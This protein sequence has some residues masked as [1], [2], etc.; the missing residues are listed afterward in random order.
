M[1]T[2][3]K[4]KGGNGGAAVS[5]QLQRTS[6]APPKLEK[7]K[8]KN[9][10]F[11]SRVSS[12]GRGQR[13]GQPGR[14]G[15]PQAPQNP[16]LS[17]PHQQRGGPPFP[18]VMPPFPY[19]PQMGG[20]GGGGPGG[21]ASSQLVFYPTGAY[22]PGQGRG[23][24]RGA[25]SAAFV[26]PHHGFVPQPYGYPS[27]QQPYA[28]P[29]M[30]N[31]YQP[32]SGAMGGSTGGVPRRQ[33]QARK[34]GQLTRDPAKQHGPSRPPRANTVPSARP[35]KALQ[36]TDPKT[37]KVITF[38]PKNK[39]SGE[40]K[41]LGVGGGSVVLDQ[42]AH[43]RVTAHASVAPAAH[44]NYNPYAPLPYQQ[45]F[46]GM[47]AQFFGG[48][49]MQ[50][51]QHMKHPHR[52][53]QPSRIQQP[54]SAIL[55]HDLKQSAK[56]KRP[57]SSQPQ[58]PQ[59]QPQ[60]Q[61]QPQPQQ[62]QRKEKRK[63]KQKQ[64][65]KQQKHQ[66]EEGQE[67]EE[68]QQPR[69]S[70]RHSQQ[71]QQHRHQRQ[72]QVQ[73]VAPHHA[74]GNDA[75]HGD[76]SSGCAAGKTARHH[77]I[78]QRTTSEPTSQPSYAAM[79][80]RH[81]VGAVD[82]ENR[83]GDIPGD[84]T[85]DNSADSSGGGPSGAHLAHAP[86]P[87]SEATDS[88]LRRAEQ[89]R[90][91]EASLA[92]NL[93]EINKRRE[94]AKR[95]SNARKMAR[96]RLE[97]L[98]RDVS[99]EEKAKIKLSKDDAAT[100]PTLGAET[101]NGD[102]TNH[103]G[104]GEPIGKNASISHANEPAAIP[105]YHIG[106]RAGR[107]Q[108]YTIAELRSVK[109]YFPYGSLES[110]THLATLGVPM[111]YEIVPSTQHSRHGANRGLANFN[112]PP[113]SSAPKSK[114]GLR[115]PNVKGSAVVGQGG[116]ARNARLG[117]R[118]ADPR[119]SVAGGKS[120]F[121]SGPFG[122]ARMGMG[123]SAFQQQQ[124]PQQQPRG[125][126]VSGG[127]MGM[128]SARG[129]A[130]NG[131]G[132]DDS[133]DWR[134]GPRRQVVAGN[135]DPFCMNPVTLHKAEKAWKPSED[136]TKSS[137]IDVWK[138][139]IGAILNKLSRENFNKLAD[140]M[141]NMPMES[142]EM[143]KE[144][145]NIIFDKALAESFYSDMYADLCREL[146]MHSATWNFTQVKSI[147]DPDTGAPKYFWAARVNPTEM[148][149]I[150]P[151]ATADEAR[152]K[153]KKETSFKRILL[154]KCQE[155]FE[156]EDLYN[157]AEEAYVALLRSAEY[158]SLD[159]DEKVRRKLQY[160]A[161]RKE[162]K[163]RMLGNVQ[164]IGE[165]FK[166]GML[167]ERIM[168]ECV[169]KMLGGRDG[170]GAAMR[171]PDGEEVEALCK[172]VTTIGLKLDHERAKNYMDTYFCRLRLLSRHPRL[173]PRTK[174]M[175]ADLIELR[176]S[177]WIPRRK[178]TIKARTKA[179]VRAEAEDEERRKEHDARHGGRYGGGGNFDRRRGRGD[180]AGGRDRRSGRAMPSAQSRREQ[181][182]R[183]VSQDIRKVTGGPGK[184]RIKKNDDILQEARTSGGPPGK[185]SK[186]RAEKS[187]AISE[188]G[189]A[190]ACREIRSQSSY[191]TSS[192]A[193]LV[194]LVKLDLG[195]LLD[196]NIQY[197]ELVK[198]FKKIIKS[199][200]LLSPGRRV[201]IVVERAFAREAIL[202]SVTKCFGKRN[203]SKVDLLCDVLVRM[204]KDRNIARDSLESE[205][206]VVTKRIEEIAED[207]PLSIEIFSR[208][209]AQL[210]M[211]GECI[212]L[213]MVSDALAC[214]VEDEYSSS[215][216][217]TVGGSMLS[218]MLSRSQHSDAQGHQ[219]VLKMLSKQLT[220][221]DI[222]AWIVPQAGK[223]DR[224]RFIEDFQLEPLRAFF[225]D[226]GPFSAQLCSKLREGQTVDDLIVM[227]STPHAREFLADSAAALS[228]EV[229]LCVIDYVT[230]I[231]GTRRRTS[232][233]EVGDVDKENILMKDYARLL[234]NIT[235][236]CP[237]T[238]GEAQLR[239]LLGVQIFCS[240]HKCAQCAPRMFKTLYDTNVVQ[241]DIFI[242]W[243]ERRGTSSPGFEVLRKE[244]DAFITFLRRAQVNTSW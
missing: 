85:S 216:A 147:D 214:L 202:L 130:P 111:Q 12:G 168:H 101:R 160:N 192:D 81:S 10:S 238:K 183:G 201:D 104:A 139:K 68:G 3:V 20:R 150:G 15:V 157:Q 231:A 178:A 71:H 210:I 53:R 14:K 237:H 244:T 155:E 13:H 125:G 180:R 229:T 36:I 76:D 167:T 143:L 42:P 218:N 65:Q 151:Y 58:Q 163:K 206:K 98:E 66:Q 106:K 51:V 235:H 69:H 46:A 156:K 217:R 181:F 161:K 243:C 77:A 209:L 191:D 29:A 224:V 135:G 96:E 63:K 165:L 205:V 225:V 166:Q 32:P 6:S 154:N 21:P 16:Q 203:A 179:E 128:G 18:F 103:E 4:E 60:P 239:C 82:R 199:P 52:A 61:P 174:F 84:N 116:A 47:P 152:A 159:N 141:L 132:L 188:R 105:K 8:K 172:L 41:A 31:M 190:D 26:P 107:K 27:A 131:G 48:A 67:Q 221:T 123:S 62:Q 74:E 2:N 95:D 56:P 220:P 37:G 7:G 153:A 234:M 127:R 120:R 211:N 108:V 49:P 79:A 186:V 182:S 184:L 236:A 30:G 54:N 121:T 17:I 149:L 193:R 91:E 208:V 133:S 226:N 137:S 100:L 11:R 204:C 78:S 227:L 146:S 118:N 110:C 171:N 114:G 189:G 158:G 169:L 23:A 240:R 9:A 44:A 39:K 185:R 80:A 115:N 109:T 177:K 233:H 142:L 28:I 86:K 117:I 102:G 138:R 134:S 198:S 187:K 200:I 22:V 70:Q 25:G 122:G 129:K 99:T 5:E 140:D 90:Q 38:S 88:A 230:A 43:Q 40:A 19:T 242:E 197:D 228:Q 176:K 45:G 207:A 145:M 73:T 119:N 50:H 215:V 136:A 83:L 87:K 92:A 219:P 72:E 196:S 57:P 212:R 222:D 223:V 24:T 175:C 213:K 113:R 97:R 112:A 144:T 194:K 1:K 232:D 162:I 164:F 59:Q 124:H 94:Q 173:E 170:N 89:E 148:D 126:G 64:R 75:T 34:N 93:A 33:K 241:E 195:D 35:R 55:G